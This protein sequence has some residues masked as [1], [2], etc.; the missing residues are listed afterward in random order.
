MNFCKIHAMF[1]KRILLFL[2]STSYKFV[3]VA[4]VVVAVNLD[5]Y[6]TMTSLVSFYHTRILCNEN[7][8]KLA[9]SINHT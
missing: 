2:S 1:Y 3:T 4:V 9:L 6:M 5:S 8:T 7:Y